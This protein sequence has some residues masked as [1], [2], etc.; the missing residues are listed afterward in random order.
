MSWFGIYNG[1][2]ETT[3]TDRP[4]VVKHS[5]RR[6]AQGESEGDIEVISLQPLR[7]GS[8]HN[9]APLRR[10]SPGFLFAC[11]AAALLIVAFGLVFSLGMMTD[12]PQEIGP[13]F[14][15]LPLPEAE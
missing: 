14:G 8:A 4:R 2:R 13:K 6:P 11:A 15:W 7:D 9:A 3:G 12:K 10:R 5:S 1:A